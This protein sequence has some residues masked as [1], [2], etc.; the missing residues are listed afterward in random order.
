L[1]S[2]DS[3]LGF[4]NPVLS[5]LQAR[6]LTFNPNSEMQVQTSPLTDTFP[7]I[8]IIRKGIL[9]SGFAVGIT[10]VSALVIVF[11][12]FY[13][14]AGGM[15]RESEEGTYARLLVS[16]ISLGAIMIGKTFY[17][18]ALNVI[19]IFI[20]LGFATFAY[21][22][23][24]NT[25]LGTVLAVSLLLALLTMGF[26]F[27]ISALGLGVR[28]VVIIE[29]F[30]VLFLFAF[31]GFM[32]DRELLRGISKTISILLPWSYGIEVSRATM[33]TGQPLLH[34]ARPL[35]FV[36]VSIAAFYIVSYLLLRLS[37][38]RLIK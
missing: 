1:Y 4:E 29:F 30:L 33:L 19:R 8:Q 28:S 31:S 6:L 37:R 9:F 32:I 13:E 16:P 7:Q 21:G 38:E 35:L 36:G 10:V 34:L 15:S 23:R 2:D 3:A 27:M 25:D 5:A 11:A 17:D 26:A 24:L 18:S 22:A 20:V 12:T 14:I